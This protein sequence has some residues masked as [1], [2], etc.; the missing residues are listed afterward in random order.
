MKSKL[1]DLETTVIEEAHDELG[2]LFEGYKD[3]ILV[4]DTRGVQLL[5]Q[6]IGFGTE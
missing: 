4:K 1:Q 5:L 6:S 2:Q 3:A